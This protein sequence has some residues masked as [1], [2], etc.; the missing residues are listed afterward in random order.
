MDIH[1]LVVHFPIALLTIYSLLEVAALRPR[2]RTPQW[3]HAKLLLLFIGTLWALAA[4]STWENAADLSG[5][6]SLTLRLHEGAASTT[7]GIYKGITIFYLVGLALQQSTFTRI[8]S[9]P[10]FI[11]FL[12]KLIALLNRLRIPALAA[13]IG[14]LGLN[15]VGALGGT[16]V[17]GPNADPITSALNKIIN[18]LDTTYDLSSMIPQKD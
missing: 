6:K 14:F 11:A 13:I 1:P 8:V 18:H 17:Y 4:L 5:I 15:L 12:R 7:A 9:F 10:K 2:F 16:L 3:T